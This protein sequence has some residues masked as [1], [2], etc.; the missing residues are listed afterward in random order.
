MT[1][2]ELFNEF[3]G[4]YASAKA[5]KARVTRRSKTKFRIYCAPGGSWKLYSKYKSKHITGRPFG[6]YLEFEYPRCVD[7]SYKLFS[8]EINEEAL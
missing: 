3:E 1:L 2:L 5:N 7:S 4:I 8:G 6:S